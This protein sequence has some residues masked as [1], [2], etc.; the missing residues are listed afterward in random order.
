MQLPPLPGGAA[1]APVHGVSEYVCD[2]PSE[3]TT[4]YAAVDAAARAAAHGWV[5]VVPRFAGLSIRIAMHGLLTLRLPTARDA[6]AVFFEL[7]FKAQR[8]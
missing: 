5:S 4:A 6:L 3:R 1:S 7:F 8:S 2:A